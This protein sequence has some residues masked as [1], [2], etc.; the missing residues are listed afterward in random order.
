MDTNDKESCNPKDSN[1]FDVPVIENIID[2]SEETG[3]RFRIQ[4]NLPKYTSEFT[5]APS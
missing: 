5:H 4:F 3:H 2:T 1:C